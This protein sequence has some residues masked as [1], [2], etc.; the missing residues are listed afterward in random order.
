MSRVK[1]GRIGGDFELGFDFGF[2]VF[3]GQY[4][5]EIE[6]LDWILSL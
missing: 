4:S 6:F 5:L 3:R 1:D 2:W